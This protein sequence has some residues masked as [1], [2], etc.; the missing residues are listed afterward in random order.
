MYERQCWQIPSFVTFRGYVIPKPY[1]V[2]SFASNSPRHLHVL[3]HDDL[4]LCMQGAEVG[5]F[6]QVDRVVLE[7]LLKQDD[8][9]LRPAA[10][11]EGSM[12]LQY[13]LTNTSCARNTFVGS[14]CV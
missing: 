13:C 7:D 14:Q 6:K 10:C 12:T 11:T 8:G 3:G 2:T 1:H 9:F 4:S 5:V